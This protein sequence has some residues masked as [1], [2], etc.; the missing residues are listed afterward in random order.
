MD[1]CSK[2]LPGILSSLEKLHIA[3]DSVHTCGDVLCIEEY[4]GNVERI[5]GHQSR[6]GQLWTD[7]TYYVHV[8]VLR[9]L[10]GL[11]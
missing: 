10:L 4:D 11:R 1:R 2:L 6:R 7:I 5:I 9:R 3:H 8:F